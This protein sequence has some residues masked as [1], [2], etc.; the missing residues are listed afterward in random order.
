MKRAAAS[1]IVVLVML[2]FVVGI[3]EA[4]Q[5]TKVSKI[6]WLGIGTTTSNSRFEEFRRALRDL[7]Y[8][9]GKNIIFE[10]RPLIIS[11]TG[12]PRWLKNWF[13]SRST[14]SS[15]VGPLRP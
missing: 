5:P 7:G 6:G 15:R 10:Y 2:L 9:E 3:A 11:S 4:Q 14:Y 1:S 13:G 12:S 8:A